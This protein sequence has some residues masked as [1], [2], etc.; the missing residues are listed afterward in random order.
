MDDLSVDG[1]IDEC[2]RDSLT[3]MRPRG[4]SRVRL[5]YVSGW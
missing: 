3:R 4:S 5:G 1:E 2:M